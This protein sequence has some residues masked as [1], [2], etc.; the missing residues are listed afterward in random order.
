[1]FHCFTRTGS[2]LA[3][4][5]GTSFSP[6]SVSMAVSLCTTKGKE[7]HL[8]L[9]SVKRWGKP[10][11]QSDIILKIHRK[12]KASQLEATPMHINAMPNKKNP[13]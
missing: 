11:P 3:F 2:V 5:A 6:S 13:R 4:L 7:N 9:S 12:L 10:S 1:M 8:S